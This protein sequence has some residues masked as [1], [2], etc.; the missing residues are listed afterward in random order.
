MTHPWTI[1]PRDS[2][3]VV[4][5][6][7][8]VFRQLPLEKAP[9]SPPLWQLCMGGPIQLEFIDIH[10]SIP[11]NIGHFLKLGITSW[12]KLPNDRMVASL[13]R[14]LP[15]SWLLNLPRRNCWLRK[16]PKWRYQICWV[17]HISMGFPPIE[18]DGVG[19]DLIRPPIFCP[20]SQQFTAERWAVE[21]MMRFPSGD[22][23]FL[24]TLDIGPWVLD[25]TPQEELTVAKT[26]IFVTWLLW[27]VLRI[28]LHWLLGH[29]SRMTVMSQELRTLS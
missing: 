13:L 5:F 15:Q 28:S 23:V 26:M 22:Q 21:E 18:G 9:C 2:F 20:W 4:A 12:N 25:H 8:A 29:L 11:C 7:K 1:Q 3:F 17:T 27:I 14:S 16:T 19:R 10:G 24:G 6:T